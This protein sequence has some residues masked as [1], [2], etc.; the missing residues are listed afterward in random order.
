[1]KQDLT[2]KKTYYTLA[3]HN[4]DV[5]VYSNIDRVIIVL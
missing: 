5:D 2:N 1:M 4:N 3:Y